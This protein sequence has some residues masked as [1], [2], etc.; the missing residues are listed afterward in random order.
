MRFR[1]EWALFDSMNICVRS[2]L[3]CVLIKKIFDCNSGPIIRRLIDRIKRNVTFGKRVSE[4]SL[5]EKITF[6]FGKLL[7]PKNHNY[8]FINN[9]ELTTN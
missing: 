4:K 8:N 9:A 6:N 5:I 3:N 2:E 1:T 7:K